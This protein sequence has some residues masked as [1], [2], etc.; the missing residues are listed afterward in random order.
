MGALRV[1]AY[2]FG[3]SW[4]DDATSCQAAEEE[5][6]SRDPPLVDQDTPSSAKR[7]WLPLGVICSVDVRRDGRPEVTR[8]QSWGAT[9]TALV[10]IGIAMGAA[11]RLLASRPGLRRARR[12]PRA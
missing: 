5:V 9:I 6:G 10:S 2:P 3:T 1:G 11:L 8:H 7:T 4:P 12:G